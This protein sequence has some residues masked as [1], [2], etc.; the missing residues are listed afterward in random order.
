M[1]MMMLT[2]RMNG[3]MKNICADFV[4]LEVFLVGK[5]VDTRW[6]EWFRR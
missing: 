6:E 3:R 5:S 4:V 1:A 2:V